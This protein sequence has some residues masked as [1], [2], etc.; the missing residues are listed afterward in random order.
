M[1]V[2]THTE[3]FTAMT[4]RRSLSFRD[5]F[6]LLLAFLITVLSSVQVTRAMPVDRPLTETPDAEAIHVFPPAPVAEGTLVASPPAAATAMPLE[7]DIRALQGLRD[8]LK[9]G[10]TVTQG[11][12]AHRVSVL[13]TGTKNDPYLRALRPALTSVLYDYDAPERNRLMALAALYKISPEVTLH[14]VKTRVDQEPS[15]RV[16]TTMENVLRGGWTPEMGLL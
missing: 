6:F 4:V 1:L 13:A 11:R 12:A 5:T 8:M 7:R 3:A 2:L 10:G 14:S 9:H 15:D 16:Q